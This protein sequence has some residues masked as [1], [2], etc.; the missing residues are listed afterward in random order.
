MT[1]SYNSLEEFKEIEEILGLDL[2]KEAIE[3]I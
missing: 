2:D 1:L 3:D